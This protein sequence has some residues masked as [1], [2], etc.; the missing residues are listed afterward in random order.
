MQTAF[1][2]NVC[3]GTALRN[4]LS[5]SY[6]AFQ[7]LDGALTGKWR[8]WGKSAVQSPFTLMERHRFYGTSLY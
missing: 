4:E 7:Y 6:S 3:A 8:E 1:A 2:F 5:P